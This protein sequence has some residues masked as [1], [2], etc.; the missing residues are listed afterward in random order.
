MGPA[1]NLCLSTA[2]S[3]TVSSDVS[4]LLF[5][6]S[7]ALS[8]GILETDATRG[9]KRQIRDKA[10]FWA[11]NNRVFRRHGCYQFLKLSNLYLNV[12]RIDFVRPKQL[13]CFPPQMF[14]F[15]HRVLF[16]QQSWMQPEVAR[17]EGKVQVECL[18][19]RPPAYFDWPHRNC[20]RN[21]QVKN[22]Q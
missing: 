4:R 13:N 8:W 18:H 21:P 20:R 5:V 17:G 10:L 7:P 1:L 16:W 15:H 2:S 9:R 3:E 12:S 14:D 6:T 11:D 19:A 22:T